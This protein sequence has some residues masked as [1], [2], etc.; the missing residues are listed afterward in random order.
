MTKMQ[1]NNKAILGFKDYG[2]TY[3]AEIL[4]YFN[5]DLQLVLTFQL[6]TRAITNES[7]ND[8][9]FEPIYITIISII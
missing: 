9:I 2:S 6:K 3:N 8:D 5:P 4:N 1:K 7:D